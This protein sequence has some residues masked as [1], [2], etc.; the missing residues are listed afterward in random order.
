[1]AVAD[2]R[3]FRR[4]RRFRYFAGRVIL[5]TAKL[6]LTLLL[7]YFALALLGLIPLNNDFQPGEFLQG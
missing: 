5:Q 3:W 2:A 4:L 7:L 6:L 1:M